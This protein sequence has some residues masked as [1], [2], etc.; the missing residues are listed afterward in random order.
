MLSLVTLPISSV[1]TKID[2]VITRMLNEH[3]QCIVVCPIS[4]LHVFELFLVS[5]TFCTFRCNAEKVRGETGDGVTHFLNI[6]SQSCVVNPESRN[7]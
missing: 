4:E 5:V 3:V 6:I 1:Q 2:E 7:L